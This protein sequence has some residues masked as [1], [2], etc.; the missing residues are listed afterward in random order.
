MQNV[1]RNRKCKGSRCVYEKGLYRIRT[2]IYN[3]LFVWGF[4]SHS[5]VFLLIWRRHYYRWRAANFDLCSAL[6][7]AIEQ[8]GF[9][10][11]LHLMWHG[12]SVIMVIS[13]DPW[14]WHLLPSVWQWSCHYLFSRLRPIA[15][16]IRTLNPP[17]AGWTLYRLR[18]RSVDVYIN[19]MYRNE[20]CIGTSSDQ[21]QIVH[22]FSMCIW[23][24]SV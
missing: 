13:E 18:Y 12:T 24:E 19:R 14:H 2:C 8:W 10:N 15:G 9:F 6:M 22:R 11:V 5:R 4:T 21:Y 1:Y 23:T 17:L 16:G 20:T 7:A 3:G